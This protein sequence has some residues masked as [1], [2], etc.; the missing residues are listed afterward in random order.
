MWP[1]P[2]PKEIIQA[3]QAQSSRVWKDKV[4]PRGTIFLIVKYKSGKGSYQA[5]AKIPSAGLTE[6][7][8]KTVYGI[9]FQ[10]IKKKYGV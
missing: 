5:C 8:K 6:E 9:L 4:A 7:L 2:K 3:Y 10:D 1:F